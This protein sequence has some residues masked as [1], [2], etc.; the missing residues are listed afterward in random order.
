MCKTFPVGWLG[1]WVA[2]SE[3]LRIRLKLSI[4]G[5]WAKLSLAIRLSLTTWGWNFGLTGALK[6][7]L[8]GGGKLGIKLKLSFSW[9]SSLS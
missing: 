4:A 5:A 9:G 8:V 7:F 1:G 6:T 3:K 2:G